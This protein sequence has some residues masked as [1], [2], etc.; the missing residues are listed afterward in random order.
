MLGNSG[1]TIETHVSPEPGLSYV[2]KSGGDTDLAKQVAIC[3][4]LKEVSPE[5]RKAGSGWYEMELLHHT[6]VGEHPHTTLLRITH[7]LMGKVWCLSPLYSSN[8]KWLD[9]LSEQVKKIAPWIPEE[10]LDRV[11]PW[12]SSM[13]YCMTHGDPTI[14]NAMQRDS[15]DI[16]LIDPLPPR[17]ATPSMREV[18][19]GKMLQS[20]S[21]WEGVRS[22][23]EP[24]RMNMDPA[25]VVG[26][27]MPF[28]HRISVEA[29]AARCYLWAAV[30]C[31]RVVHHGTVTKAIRDWSKQESIRW[32]ENAC[33]EIQR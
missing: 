32:T 13:V 31:A 29:W 9:E 7:A 23:R 8:H 11:Y 27:C 1:A 33:V 12:S 30:H 6:P 24:S 26:A 4:Y 25:H 21:G 14:A 19:V 18:D 15:G 10:L 5:I 22:G 16:V 28:A 3:K 20:L 2:R 17:P